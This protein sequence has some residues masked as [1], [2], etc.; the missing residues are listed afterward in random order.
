ML[1]HLSYV[2]GEDKRNG[3]IPIRKAFEIITILSNKEPLNKVV[4]V[5]SGCPD[6]ANAPSRI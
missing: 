3:E 6:N 1:H 4:F 2:S 5:V